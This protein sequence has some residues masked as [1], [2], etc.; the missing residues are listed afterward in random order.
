MTRRILA[1][2]LLLTAL[3]VTCVCIPLGL[4]A[5]RHDRTL[6]TLRTTSAV[7][8]YA[9]EVKWRRLSAGAPQLPTSVRDDAHPERIQPDDDLALYLPDGSFVGSSGWPIELTADQLAAAREQRL[10]LEPAAENGHR[11]V[12]VTPVSNANGL[13]AIL[14]VGRSDAATRAEIQERWIRLAVGSGL[15]S[16]IALALS[17]LL[18]R[19]VGRPL[20]GLERAAAEFG[21][22][23][24]STRAD[25]A[26]GPAEVREL[27]TTFDAMAAR[28]EELVGG[29][30]AFLADV[31]HQLRT[32]L[33]AMR[34]R[35]ELLAQDVAA[36]QAA[37][38]GG[39][40]AEVHRLSRMV[41]GLLAMARAQ[42]PGASPARAPV[43]VGRVVEERAAA[44]RP[45]A[46]A[47]GVAL[48][49]DVEDPADA[50]LTAGHL[51]QVLDNL[52]SNALEA[53][54]R[55]GRVVVRAR[56]RAGEAPVLA[57]LEV[58]EPATAPGSAGRAGARG[59]SR[60]VAAAAAGLIRL[61]VADDGPGM[62]AAA[63]AVAFERFRQGT[64]ARPVR[65]DRRGHGLGLAVVHA[66]VVADGGQVTLDEA[67][68]GGLLVALDL[69]AAPPGAPGPAGGTGRG[70]RA[71][72]PA[73]GQGLARGATP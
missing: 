3:L 2:Q 67:E 20:R 12:V 5:A 1:V 38:V 64:A 30:R 39:T 40:L 59:S 21:D 35:L 45:V 73:A 13:V 34:L 65:A 63:R 60:D 28:I 66:L 4:E 33:T 43:R 36:D 26:G 37:E 22:G 14:A 54:P 68:S 16:L 27:A 15:A 55:G 19:W 72:A 10:V 9:A 46:R 61:T 6:L 56:P 50:L 23:Q 31:S 18:A 7:E 62:T 25:A 71:P 42:A 47:A 57:A 11:L 70:Q 29:Q 41:D 53:A 58:L 49:T 69:P 8:A 32:P 51:E 44:W 24:L 52:L 48:D 17:V